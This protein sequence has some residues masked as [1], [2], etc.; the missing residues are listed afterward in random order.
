M[1]GIIMCLIFFPVVLIPFF[2]MLSNAKPKKDIILGVTIPYAEKDNEEVVQIL[3][4]YKKSVKLLLVFSVIAFIPMPFIPYTSIMLTFLMLVLTVMLAVQALVQRHYNKRLRNIKDKNG[5]GGVKT[6]IVDIGTLP[7]SKGLVSIWWF[8]V[9]LIISL[10]PS[11]LTLFRNENLITLILYMIFSVCILLFMFFYVMMKRQR[12]DIVGENQKLNMALTSIRRRNWSIMWLGLAFLT[13][14]LNIA[15]YFSMPYPSG[16]L[17]FTIIYTV[18]VF[19]IAMYTEFKTRGMQQKL[20]KDAGGSILADEDDYWIW[21]MFYYN[22]NDRHAMKN[23]RVG[24]G[25]TMNLAKPSGKF[26][27]GLSALLIILLPFIGVWL[28]TEEFTPVNVEIQSGYVISSHICEEYKIPISAIDEIEL[29]ENQI[30]MSRVVGTGM[31]SLSKGLFNAGNYGM[32]EVCLNPKK[33]PYLLI[34]TKEKSYILGS[35][36][37]NGVEQAY[38]ELLEEK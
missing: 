7:E 2:T 15:A 19:A 25:M 11:V 9:A 20:T 21:G 5:W 37:S 4:D 10:I 14:L 34:R 24:M 35:S 1:N 12:S 36:E 17:V 27:M 13:A 28:M 18:L 22:P 3:K 23:E 38:D 31:D 29:I 8:V 30:S 16:A 6:T 33:P 26:V 32:V